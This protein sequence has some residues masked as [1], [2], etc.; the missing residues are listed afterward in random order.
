MDQLSIPSEISELRI[1]VLIPCL[2]ESAAIGSVVRKTRAV[3]PGARIHVFD[4]ASTDDTV[5][6]ATAAGATV[7]R[8]TMR[9]KGNVLRQA[10]ALVDADLYLVI[11]GDGTYDVTTAPLLLKRLV[12]DELDMVVG[13]RQSSDP[14]AYRLG[15]RLGNRIFNSGAKALFGCTVR[16]IFSGYRAM[17]RPFVKSF[18]ALATG[19]E[20]ETELFLHAVALRAPFAEIGTA[21]AARGANSNSKLRTLKDGAQIGWFM[22]RLLKHTRPYLVFGTL[23]VIATLIGFVL[24]IPVVAEYLKTGL[25]PRFPSAFTAGSS[26]VIAAVCVTSGLVLDSLAVIQREQKRLRYLSIGRFCSADRVYES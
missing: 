5:A 7:H 20:V 19:F 1:S 3:L 16:D 4:N 15:H 8:V 25:V 11:D 17:S 18:P 26:F 24:G 6:E 13:D 9:G 22:L 12:V 23:A 10:F 2:N 21:Y 14:E